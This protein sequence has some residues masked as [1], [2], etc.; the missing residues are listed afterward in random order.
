MQPDHQ[1][2]VGG[3]L[4]DTTRRSRRQNGRL[5]SVHYHVSLYI[6]DNSCVIYRLITMARHLFGWR[7]LPYDEQPDPYKCT[8]GNGIS[9]P[10]GIKYEASAVAKGLLSELPSIFLGGLR[11]RGL[12]GCDRQPVAPNPRL[13]TII[14]S[15]F[16]PTR[17][18]HWPNKINCNVRVYV[19]IDLVITGV[20]DIDVQGRINFFNGKMRPP[21]V[22]HNL[23]VCLYVC[24]VA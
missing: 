11:V 10:G 6:N 7:S 22:T 9:L 18:I 4:A 8:T 19:I 12:Y 13:L 5:V 2:R 15:A 21:T 24:L 20:T 14:A 16:F 1:R 23:S 17:A 3:V